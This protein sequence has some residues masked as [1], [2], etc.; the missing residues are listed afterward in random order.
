L[1]WCDLDLD[2]SLVMINGQTQRIGGALACCPPKTEAGRRCIALDRTT[3]AAL[4]RH[5]TGQRAELD[6]LGADGG[7]YVFTNQRGAPM[8]PDVLTR[9]FNA[10]VAGSGLPPVR[11]HDLRHGAGSLALQAGADLKVIQDQLGHAGIVF[12][13]DTYLTVVLQVAHAAAE[14]VA[15]SF[16]TPAGPLPALTG[17]AGGPLRS[18]RSSGCRSDARSDR[19]EQRDHTKEE[20][21]AAGKEETGEGRKEAIPWPHPG[22]TRGDGRPPVGENAKVRRGAPSGTRT[23][24]PQI[25]SAQRRVTGPDGLG[26]GGACPWC[27]PD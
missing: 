24:N 6:G 21:R 26:G 25:K 4:R 11:L 23:P 9:T 7:G 19:E 16:W 20:M 22:P 3:V 1:R 17:H 10:L 15:G 8:S 14:A 13:A 2:H 12:T 27:W 5:R 18:E